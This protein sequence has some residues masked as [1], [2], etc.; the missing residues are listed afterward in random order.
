MQVPGDSFPAPSTNLFANLELEDLAF[1]AL[2]EL[3]KSAN[4]IYFI[5][6][7]HPGTAIV[8]VDM[9]VWTLLRGEM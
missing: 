9:E 1:Y 8:A 4:M 7:Q 2:V 3:F 6:H 5:L